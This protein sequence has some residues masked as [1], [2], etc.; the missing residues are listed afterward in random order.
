[1]ANDLGGR[2]SSPRAKGALVAAILA[3]YSVG[4][5][6]NRLDAAKT[7]L[8]SRAFFLEGPSREAKSAAWKPG[9]MR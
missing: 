9:P 2:R 4:L 5:W 8:P 7:R 3:F 6:L 1:L